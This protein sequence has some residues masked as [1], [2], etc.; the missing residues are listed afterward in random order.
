MGEPDSNE[1]LAPDTI[2]VQSLA[3]TPETSKC[4]G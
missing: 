1:H 4:F 3:N 2:S